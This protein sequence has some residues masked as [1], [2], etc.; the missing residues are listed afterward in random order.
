MPS[1]L[2]TGAN[3]GIGL[4]LVELYLG[5]QWKV[6]ASCRQPDN[7]LALHQLQQ[8]YGDRL[9]ILKLD[10]NNQEQIDK[11]VKTLTGQTIDVLI[12]NAGIVEMEGYG[13][14]AY[15]GLDDPD[16]R[17]YDYQQW[18]EILTTN[19]LGPARVTGSF[20]DNLRTA[21]SGVVVMMVSGLAS[22]ANTWQA[23]RYAYRTSKA[24]L[25]MLMRSS[26]EWLESLGITVVAVSPGWTRTEMGGPNATNSVEQS[27]AGVKTV[28]AGITEKDAGKFLNFDGTTLPW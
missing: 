13:S 24:A 17:H 4:G 26:G 16:L 28:I 11:A 3:R 2:I 14:G 12:N 8:R 21:D 10:V 6:F 27:A 5:D 23:G 9:S 15:E 19:V 25:N 22:I 18:Q 1:L 7:A 20:V